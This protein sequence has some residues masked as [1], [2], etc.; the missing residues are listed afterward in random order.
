L[1]GDIGL[2]V[3]G[4]YFENLPSIRPDLLPKS[5]VG[6]DKFEVRF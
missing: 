2:K 4:L 6:L 1:L 5:I 3:D